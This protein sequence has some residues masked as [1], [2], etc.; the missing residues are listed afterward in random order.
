MI[1]LFKIY[2]SKFLINQFIYQDEAINFNQDEESTKTINN[3][4]EIHSLTECLRVS[5]IRH[6]I[7]PM[8]YP[9]TS[10]E[11]IAICYNVENWDS[12]ESAFNNVSN[13]I[14]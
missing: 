9:P 6:A 3:I 8:E 14:L 10:M 4:D 12:Y 7:F 2:N 11:G 1:I 13:L 5:E